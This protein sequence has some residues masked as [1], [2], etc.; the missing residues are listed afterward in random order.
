[1][2]IIVVLYCFMCIF[3]ILY[4]YKKTNKVLISINIYLMI[5]SAMIVLYS[6]KLIKY[7][8]LSFQTW[9]VIFLSTITVF[10][11]YHFGWKMKI[12]GVGK[13]SNISENSLKRFLY[14][15]SLIALIAI[16]PNTFFLIQRYGINILSKTA[17]IYVD[18]L[19]GTAPK[20]IPYFSCFAQV[21]CIFA[22]IYFINYGF[23]WFL[24][25]PVLLSMIS[26]LSSGSR[27]GLILT[28][29]FIIMP[30]ILMM[31]KSK[32]NLKKEKKKIIL[33]A[34]V[35]LVLFIILT[36]NRSSQLDPENYK[37]I[38]STMLPI[39]Y[40]LPALYKLYAYFT[41]SVGV[42]N[43]FLNDPDFYFGE[44]SFGVFYN[45]LNKMGMD[46]QYSRYQKFYNIP[47]QT[48]VGTWLRE[49]IQ[50]FGMVGMF[51][52][53]FIFCCFVGYYEKKALNYQQKE[54]L[55]L[56]SVLDTIFVMS[57][58]VWYFREGTMMVVVLICLVFKYLKFEK[59]IVFHP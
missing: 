45:F 28:I 10:I 23:K 16:I 6:F 38:S 31:K 42:L 51:I 27:G 21:S 20:N 11:G 44:N 3:M 35:V 19:T 40:A 37:Y 9:L 32:I 22:G 58:F 59:K 55:L 52:V 29:F 2:A 8:D 1:M 18:N 56:A 12:K 36:V 26:I 7:Y 49:L 13:K 53:V 41:G 34:M 17:Q 39:A 50:D 25:L 57:F 15:T 33:V 47:I 30:I 43:A 54:D 48:N 46:F 4:N 24:A 14:V 5:W